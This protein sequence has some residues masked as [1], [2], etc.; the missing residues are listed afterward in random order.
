MSQPKPKPDLKIGIDPSKDYSKWEL[1][2]KTPK[3][4]LFRY[5]IWID[6]KE[7]EIKNKI[8]GGFKANLFGLAGISIEYWTDQQKIT[9]T[10]KNFFQKLFVDVK[11]TVVGLETTVKMD[12]GGEEAGIKVIDPLGDLVLTW[13]WSDIQKYLSEP[14]P[15]AAPEAE[16]PPADGSIAPPLPQTGPAPLTNRRP[17]VNALPA[18]RTTMPASCAIPNTVKIEETREPGYGN[19]Q[20]QNIELTAYGEGFNP[21]TREDD[22]STI[23]IKITEYNE[24]NKLLVK[25]KRASGAE[26]NKEFDPKPE[27]KEKLKSGQM[28]EYDVLNA[29]I[30]TYMPRYIL[31]P[32]AR[33]KGDAAPLLPTSVAQADDFQQAGI[34]PSPTQDVDAVGT[35][36]AAIDA[37]SRTGAAASGLSVPALGGGIDPDLG[38]RPAGQIAVADGAGVGDASEHMATVGHIAPPSASAAG[39]MVP[40]SSARPHI[41]PPP[42][43]TPARPLHAAI[44]ASA[45][46]QTTAPRPH[47]AIPLPE[48]V[49]AAPT[50]PP[51][52]ADPSIEPDPEPGIIIPVSV[53]P[54]KTAAQGGDPHRTPPTA[55]NPQAYAAPQDT[56]QTSDPRIEALI[57]ALADLRAEFE[58]LRA[59]FPAHVMTIVDDTLAQRRIDTP[60]AQMRAELPSG[61][62]QRFHSALKPHGGF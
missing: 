60:Y 6:K 7:L 12:F 23:S 10:L 53:T 61:Q 3:N 56:S 4:K 55:L 59:A 32:G 5:D 58:A 40:D 31:S 27:W 33:M 51:A 30:C 44:H 38:S 24:I 2:V 16:P 50:S 39:L 15:E 1:Y 19:S 37:P 14:T 42:R 34:L 43:P 18:P 25:L 49:D 9:D 52:F 45:T 8:S 47:G 46:D 41:A 54:P 22:K 26:F 17:A 21:S 57:Q 20:S 28:N 29:A 13:S 35:E 36:H 48:S 11:F 62:M